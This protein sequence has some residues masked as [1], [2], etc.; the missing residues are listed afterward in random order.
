MRERMNASSFASRRD[1]AF[2]PDQEPSASSP[3]VAHPVE[4]A[5]ENAG[6]LPA[7]PVCRWHGPSRRKIPNGVKSQVVKRGPRIGQLCGIRCEC[8]QFLVILRRQPI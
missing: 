1:F 8:E 4:Y 3:V 6:T 5:R 2:A 7:G